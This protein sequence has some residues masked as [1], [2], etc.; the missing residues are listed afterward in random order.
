MEI[1]AHEPD[2]LV[3]ASSP[4]AHSV[5]VHRTSIDDGISRMRPVEAVAFEANETVAFAPGGTHF[6]LVGISFPFE[7]GQVFELELQ[8]ERAGVIRVEVPVIAPGD[9]HAHH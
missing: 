7:A 6:M 8:F 1:T 4:I 2:R 9:D 3:G 5:E